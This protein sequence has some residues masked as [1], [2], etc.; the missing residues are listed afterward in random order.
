LDKKDEILKVALRLITESGF[1]ATP[2]SKI[3]KEAGVA[4]G[5]LFHYFKTKDDL[6]LAL[7]TKHQNELRLFIDKHSTKNNSIDST[8]HVFYISTINWIHENQTAFQ[9]IQQ[10]HQSPFYQ[11]IPR[12]YINQNESFLIELLQQGLNQG[13]IKQL[14]IELLHSM[15][16]SHIIGTI[17]YLTTRNLSLEDFHKTTQKSFSLLWDMIRK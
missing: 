7:Y 2:T 1:H 12:E 17:N 5:T 14:P 3:A 16:N 10:F 15:I 8:F 9:F 6:I 13:A 11:L 4:N